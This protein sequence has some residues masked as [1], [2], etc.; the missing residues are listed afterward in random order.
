MNCCN[1]KLTLVFI[2]L[3]D[4]YEVLKAVDISLI[5][6]WKLMKYSSVKSVV[7]GE[8]QVAEGL[9]KLKILKAAPTRWLCHGEATKCL[10]SRFQPLID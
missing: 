7:Y 10:I 5:S 1:H 4:Q 2:D 8:A 3:L 9:K 6:V